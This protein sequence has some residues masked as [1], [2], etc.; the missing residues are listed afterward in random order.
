[1]Q[2][3]PSA[4]SF[5]ASSPAAAD[6]AVALAAS[7]LLAALGESRWIDAL[8]LAPQAT[9]P[10]RLEGL[11]KIRGLVRLSSRYSI[12]GFAPGLDSA[13]PEALVSGSTNSDP[14]PDSQASALRKMDDE[15]ALQAMARVAARLIQDQTTKPGP[16][17]ARDAQTFLTLQDEAG[18]LRPSFVAAKVAC[19]IA[20]A[21]AQG[22]LLS[23][24]MRRVQWDRVP[25]EWCE[26]LVVAFS[27][28]SA[29]TPD[30]FQPRASGSGAWAEW[31]VQFIRGGK[32]SAFL[33]LASAASAAGQQN[34]MLEAEPSVAYALLAPHDMTG[35]VERWKNP[36]LQAAGAGFP[37][38]AGLLST[39]MA[40]WADAY[41]ECEESERPN[42]VNRAENAFDWACEALQ[43]NSASIS[44]TLDRLVGNP[45]GP[46]GTMRTRDAVAKAKLSAF[47][48]AMAHWALKKDVSPSLD[49]WAGVALDG[50]PLLNCFLDAGLGPQA[51]VQALASA[52][53]I[54]WNTQPLSSPG[55][56]ALS[57]LRKLL[58]ARP[59]SADERGQ[60]L[61]TAALTNDP[62]FE[63]SALASLLSEQGP[64]PAADCTDA[65]MSL[66][67]KDFYG[68]HGDSPVF[69]LAR[70]LIA[71]GAEPSGPL[72]DGEPLRTALR[73]GNFQ[74]AHI[75]ADAGG[76]GPVAVKWLLA[77]RKNDEPGIR[78]WA[79][80]A[81]AV[82]EQ[83]ALQKTLASVSR[84]QA[85]PARHSRTQAGASLDTLCA[86]ASDN[87]ESASGA[88]MNAQAP[89]GLAAYPAPAI[90]PSARRI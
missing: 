59:W 45:F 3:T 39:M 57:N 40:R 77:P 28:Q 63:Q 55:S 69:G 20:E 60:A 2:D 81:Q 79:Q 46:F 88:T 75:V 48:I 71:T 51:P 68:F 31:A 80:R 27:R 38:G 64:L 30:C 72:G 66:C 10:E 8:E 65:L 12:V 18:H 82:K 35:G 78:E 21:G 67:E 19:W 24:W 42:T 62:R 4:A 52:A 70:L 58:A 37:F 90:K 85:K 34:L 50:C 33:G 16:G 86:P 17:F 44:G 54:E 13:R 83:A 22:P 15:E 61:R 23:D 43:I 84:K 76:W 56:T 36:L 29:F 7:P 73:R 5:N 26:R 49:A 89:S 74:L 9:E 1:M 14:N 87:G 41:I 11:N 53:K 6:Q 25:E 32:A 47:A